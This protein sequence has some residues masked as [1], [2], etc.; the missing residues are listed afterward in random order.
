M[1]IDA[2]NTLQDDLSISSDNQVE[3]P[4]ISDSEADVTHFADAPM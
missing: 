3:P 4:I 1:E 2:Q